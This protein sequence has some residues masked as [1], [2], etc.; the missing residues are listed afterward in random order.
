MPAL[1][2][3]PLKTALEWRT[4]QQ[5]IFVRK[6]KA[7]RNAG[8]RA[9][10]TPIANGSTNKPRQELGRRQAVFQTTSYRCFVA[11]V[12]APAPVFIRL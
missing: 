12:T 3:S 11:E 2:T 8:R 6:G 10:A 1:R 5:V 9:K 4:E 7:K